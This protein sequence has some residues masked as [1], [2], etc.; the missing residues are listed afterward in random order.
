MVKGVCLTFYAYEFQKHRGMLL[1]EWLVEFA[2]KEGIRGGTAL[3]GITG[4]GR[5]KNLHDEH[6]FELAANVLIE[7]SFVC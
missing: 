5:E 1:Y 7:V 6:F 2:K 4:F 3:R